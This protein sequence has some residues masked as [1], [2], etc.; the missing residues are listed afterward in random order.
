MKL[1]VFLLLW[2]AWIAGN[3]V[4]FLLGYGDG[5]RQRRRAQRRQGLG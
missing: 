4:S 1:D 3:L 2:V 5:R